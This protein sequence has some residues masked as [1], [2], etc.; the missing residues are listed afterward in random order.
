MYNKNVEKTFSKKYE[1]ESIIEKL[2]VPFEIKTKLKGI[3]AKIVLPK[4]GKN[5]K[6]D[7]FNV[8]V[9]NAKV[10]NG[11][12][13]ICYV[14]I[15]EPQIIITE[16]KGA[17]GERFSGLYP[18]LREQLKKID[19]YEEKENKGWLSSKKIDDLIKC[20]SKVNELYENNELVLKRSNKS[21]IKHVNGEKQEMP[22]SYFERKPER[23]Q[24]KYMEEFNGA[25]NEMQKVLAEGD[26]TQFIDYY[27]R[28]KIWQEEIDQLI[29]DV[30]GR[31]ILIEKS[32]GINL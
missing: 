22:I 15:A 26:G 3:K 16:Y 32:R 27:K 23:G 13:R 4:K 17:R 30:E 29:E 18:L 5:E 11:E 6:I 12:E 31:K 10:I 25:I 28:L 2:E 14:K 21:Y 7:R 8:Y 9:K 20:I 19:G 1:L 24:K